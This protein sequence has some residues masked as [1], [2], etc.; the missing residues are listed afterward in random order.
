[1][2]R[3]C[4]AS[5]TVAAQGSTELLEALN[6]HLEFLKSSQNKLEQAM[7]AAQPRA[8]RLIRP[9]RPQMLSNLPHSLTGVPV[10]P[11]WLDSSNSVLGRGRRLALRL[12]YFRTLMTEV[13]DK[14]VVIRED[15]D[16][17][18]SSVRARQ[19]KEAG[20]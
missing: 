9:H 16:Q 20:R 6:Q 4:L 18:K 7:M 15:L 11:A 12:S 8:P 10:L 1:M 17:G 3:A 19:Q 5:E 13:H 14:L 2:L